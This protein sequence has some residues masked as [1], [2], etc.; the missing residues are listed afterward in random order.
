MSLNNCKPNTE[1]TISRVDIKDCDTKTFLT[2][3][4]CFIGEEILVIS[5]LHQNVIIA[6]K[7]ARYSLDRDIAECILL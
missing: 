5:H 6:L 2:S 3:I 1:Y 4:G 7:D